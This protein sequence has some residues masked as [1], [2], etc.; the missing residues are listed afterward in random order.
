MSRTVEEIE[1]DLADCYAIEVRIRERIRRLRDDM[2]TM[3]RLLVIPLLKELEQARK[4]ATNESQT[5]K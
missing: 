5:T 2:K 3:S 1:A 4:E